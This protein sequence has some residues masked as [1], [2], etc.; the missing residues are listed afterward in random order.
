MA[1][2]GD[3][4]TTTV[5]T[6]VIPSMVAQKVIESAE[7]V[8]VFMPLI[9]RFDLTGPGSTTSVG[10][11]PAVA[12]TTHAEGADITPDAF[13]PSGRDLTPAEHVLDFHVARKA[14]ADAGVDLESQMINEGG[15][16]LATYRDGLFAALHGEANDS[17]PDHE[18][19]YGTSGMTTA[20]LKE[21]AQLLFN[22]KAPRADNNGAYSCVCHSSAVGE[23][24]DEDRFV[25]ASVRGDTVIPEG[26]SMNGFVKRYLNTLVY[27]S[28]D[29]VLSTTYRNMMFA[30]KAIGYGY[31]NIAN[32]ESGAM[33]E[34]LVEV[35]WMQVRR[36]WEISMTID[37][38][39][40]G[41]VDTATTNL[42][43][44]TIAT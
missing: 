3:T 8:E 18:L 2:F 15:V 32:P 17:T 34:V 6:E 23:L 28:E 19:A 12:W 29:I 44:V 40:L 7:S 43:L 16:A 31:K 10:Q 1:R 36:S 25:N 33:T 5:A 38:H 35:G 20:A 9:T 42:W 4:V 39:A 27:Q 11:N 14:L 30:K 21:G 41:I 37:A 24:F 13:Q 26:V 22:Q